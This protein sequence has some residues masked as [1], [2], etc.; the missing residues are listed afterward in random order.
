MIYKWKNIDGPAA[1][2]R[3]ESEERLSTLV[4]ISA[5]VNELGSR[6]L[7]ALGRSL[8]PARW[9]YL[10]PALTRIFLKKY[11]LYL[12]DLVGYGV[13]IMCIFCDSLIKP[14]YIK[15]KSGNS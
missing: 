13:S 8:M 3:P 14:N 12:I 4:T 2:L 5:S 7:T 15:L 9:P 6:I 10:L 11:I 1:K